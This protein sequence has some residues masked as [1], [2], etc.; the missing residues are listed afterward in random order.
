LHAESGQFIDRTV[1]NDVVNHIVC[2][3]TASLSEFGVGA[4][5]GI[6]TTTTTTSTTTTTTIFPG[7]PPSPLTGCRPSAPQKATLMLKK[8]VRV[9]T[10]FGARPP[11]TEGVRRDISGLSCTEPGLPTWCP[12]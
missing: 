10:E 11:H 8:G 5:T 1:S 3:Q 12:E 2:A 4:N 6:P 9:Q 7:C